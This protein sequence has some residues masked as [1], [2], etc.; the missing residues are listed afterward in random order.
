MK[1]RVI[2]NQQVIT[3]ADLAEALNMQCKILTSMFKRAKDFLPQD[4]YFQLTYEE[5]RDLVKNYCLSH[6]ERLRYAKRLPYV[7]DKKAVF[8]MLC[9]LKKNPMAKVFRN[10]LFASKSFSD[11][12]MDALLK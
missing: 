10:K 6:A 2:R 11:M 7:L 9:I 4:S 12:D 5:Q 3:D 1:F 8:M